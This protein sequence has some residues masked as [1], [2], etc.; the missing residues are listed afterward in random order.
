LNEGLLGEINNRERK[1][2]NRGPTNQKL[3]DI[4]IDHSVSPLA[5]TSR[6]VIP[7]GRRRKAAHF[8]RLVLQRRIVRIAFSFSRVRKSMNLAAMPLTPLPS[9]ARQLDGAPHD[10]G[11]DLIFEADIKLNVKLSLRRSSDALMSSRQ[12]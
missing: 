1:Y 6:M 7:R 12:R 8:Q 2:Q 11:A 10:L 5:E 4:S 9:D 3:S